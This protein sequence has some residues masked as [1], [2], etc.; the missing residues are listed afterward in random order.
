MPHAKILE[1]VLTL[2]P[3][4]Q[5]SPL[6]PRIPVDSD[7]RLTPL[8]PL[9]LLGF[10]L[11]DFP[12]DE[13]LASGIIVPGADGNPSL[14]PKL[15]A[16]NT[17]VLGLRDA[18]SGEFFDL[19]TPHGLV[20]GDGP[21]AF[22]AAR[23][24]HTVSALRVWDES[25]PAWDECEPMLFVASD[26]RDVII[27]RSLG[28]PAALGDGFDYL[29]AAQVEGLHCHFEW[30]HERGKEDVV[31][32]AESF[33]V[34]T[35]NPAPPQQLE[36]CPDADA[37]DDSADDAAA[38]GDDA[39][40]TDDDA[41]AD[42]AADDADEDD[43]EDDNV[44]ARP[45][46]M[47]VG[48]SL[49]TLSFVEPGMYH[50]AL[51]AFFALEQ[52]HDLGLLQVFA[53]NPTPDWGQELRVACERGAIID[54]RK[55]IV[56]STLAH[57]SDLFSLKKQAA[58][59][60]EIPIDTL[61]AAREQLLTAFAAGRSDFTAPN[62]QQKAV[63]DYRRIVE[64]DLIRPLLDGLEEADAIDRNALA[65]AGSLL[66]TY[67]DDELA[68]LVEKARQVWHSGPQPRDPAKMKERLALAKE[69]LKFLT[70]LR[71]CIPRPMIV[72]RR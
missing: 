3:P 21:S 48:W 71:T 1:M 55:A 42:D 12:F 15:S 33:A 51:R 16:A 39:H 68:D 38:D 17:P 27:F 32:P 70:E 5:M 65:T 22:A 57:A 60:P 52:Q 46:L 43:D 56:A 31:R 72:P 11:A 7:A 4:F 40:D 50:D 6:W 8:S 67:Y 28:L 30:W 63:A 49:W 53:W 35:E 47:F 45:N 29:G 69:I 62:R 24:L 36:V 14:N 41:A 13:L 37:D 66:R 59:P 10:L 25:L 23:D 19:V 54:V 20:C 9:S 34:A 58:R 18:A 2:C 64:R 61:G 26:L 44:G